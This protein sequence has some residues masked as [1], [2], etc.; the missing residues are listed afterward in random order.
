LILQKPMSWS[1]VGSQ[2][3]QNAPR[4]AGQFAS[5]IA[6]PFLHLVDTISNI[7]DVGHGLAQKLGLASGEEDVP[8]AD[9]V[10]TSFNRGC[11]QNL[12]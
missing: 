10:G 4:S 11:G 6:Q 1:D 3:L 5:D 9:A 8:A 7:G 12:L 2:A